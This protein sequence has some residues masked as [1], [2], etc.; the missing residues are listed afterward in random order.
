MNCMVVAINKSINLPKLLFWRLIKTRLCQHQSFK[1]MN[2]NRRIT[3]GDV[4]S[5]HWFAACP[6]PVALKPLVTKC[7]NFGKSVLELCWFFGGAASAHLTLWPIVRWLHVIET[8][9]VKIECDEPRKQ[10]SEMKWKSKQFP[11][12]KLI[13]ITY[14]DNNKEHLWRYGPI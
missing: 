9:S 13:Y 7:E 12:E 5:G 4:V 11:S 1:K 3:V 10:N 6:K 8:P 2:L 14:F